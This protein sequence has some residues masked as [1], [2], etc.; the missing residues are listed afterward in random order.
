MKLELADSNFVI[1]R[2]VNNQYNTALYCQA[3]DKLN[4]D[5]ANKKVDFF[6]FSNNTKNKFLDE[7]IIWYNIN[8]TRTS[9]S[10]EIVNNAT[11][12]TSHYIGFYSTTINN[13]KIDIVLN[14]R[15]G[16]ES[17]IFNYL[18][19]YAYGVY[20]PKG[21]SS[22]K[23]EKT[24]NLWLLAIL[25]KATFNKAITK[26]QIPK[27][28]KKMQKNLHTFKGQLHIS[29]HIQENL[30][31]KS[32]FYCS[33]RKLT[34]DVTINQTIRYSY[35]F[36]KQ[37]GFAVLLKD[38][39]EYDQ[40]L[41]SFGVKEKKITLNDIK[42]IKYTKLNIHYKKLMELSALLLQNNSKSS[43]T[44]TDEN[45]SFAYFIDM[46]ELW[47]DY[48][49]KVL[50]KNLPEYSVYSPNEKGGVAL[51]SD[52]SRSI[53][54]DI[55]IGKD[56]EVIAILDAKYKSYKQ[57]GKYA[58]FDDSV[59]R[60]DLYQMTT[61][62]YHYGK[63]SQKIVGLFVSPVHNSFEIPKEGVSHTKHKIGVLNLN[64]DQFSKQKLDG[65]KQDNK[66]DFSTDAIQ[67]EEENFINRLKEYLQ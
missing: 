18:L 67:K 5:I 51:F 55:I 27:E 49:L 56:G 58:D 31:D 53:R 24:D 12:Y 42:N 28:Y 62:L 54:P 37:K 52:G 33:Y 4:A 40:M 15:F 38:M 21:S 65:E 2:S 9:H 43:T 30:F 14:P 44:N 48:L 26:S 10:N 64:I 39:Q 20:L 47:E 57:I 13:K 41:H 19:S 36:L 11:F 66:I 45:D 46:A 29:K 63:E 6:S 7:K 32:R 22:S 59:S 16:A 50:Q 17:G 61:Y 23:S 25:Y 34:M 60:E 8:S 35:K 1:G 3:V